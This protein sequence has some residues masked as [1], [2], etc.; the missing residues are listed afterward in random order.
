MSNDFFIKLVLSAVLGLIMGWDRQ[1]SGH[2]A[3]MRTYALVSMGSAVFTL[4][5]IHG[6]PGE[7][8]SSRV[9]GQIVTGIGFLGAGIILHKPDKVV[10]LTTAA[11]V[12][13]SSAVGMAVATNNYFL[14]IGATILTTLIFIF[15]DEYFEKKSGKGK[16]G[17]N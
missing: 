15:N 6:F 9:A 12:W 2:P 16:K 14:A 13:V 17:K 4:L 5:S 1:R 3:G 7:A 8:E 11:G 10:G